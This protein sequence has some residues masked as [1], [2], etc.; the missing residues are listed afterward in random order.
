[1]VFFVR[2]G[3]TKP[4]IM[5]KFVFFLTL[6][7]LLCFG[8]DESRQ[9]TVSYKYSIGVRQFTPF[10]G[11]KA[12]PFSTAG[13]TSNTLFFQPINISKRI[14]FAGVPLRVSVGYYKIQYHNDLENWYDDFGADFNFISVPITFYYSLNDKTYSKSSLFVFLDFYLIMCRWRRKIGGVTRGDRY[15]DG[16]WGIEYQYQISRRFSFSQ[17]LQFQTNNIFRHVDRE[18]IFNDLFWS[19]EDYFEY[20]QKAGLF[21][22]SLNYH[23]N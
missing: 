20:S 1:M 4:T 10:N 5:K 19:D 16:L 17:A 12:P 7:P 8:Q 15:Y 6:V 21:V 3:K 23:F 18:I 9:D 22:F 14:S 2:F 11:V 13:S